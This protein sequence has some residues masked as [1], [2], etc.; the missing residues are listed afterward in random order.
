MFGLRFEKTSILSMKKHF[1]QKNEHI[2]VNHCCYCNIIYGDS[3]KYL[4]QAESVHFLPTKHTQRFNPD[5]ERLTGYKHTDTAFRKSLNLPAEA[6]KTSSVDFLQTFCHEKKSVI[7]LA[8]R[9][10]SR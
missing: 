8:W 6:K 2:K 1:L 9:K 3:S 7:K 4:N 10:N 5:I